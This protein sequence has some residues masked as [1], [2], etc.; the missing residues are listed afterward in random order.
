MEGWF[1]NRGVD[2]PL[3]TIPL[4]I[5]VMV[6]LLTFFYAWYG[7]SC[8]GVGGGGGAILGNGYGVQGQNYVVLLQGSEVPAGFHYR[9]LI[10]AMFLVN[11][12]EHGLMVS[13]SEFQSSN[14]RLFPRKEEY[15]IAFQFWYCEPFIVGGG[16]MEQK[17]INQS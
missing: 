7:F 10:L 15:E 8:M 2:T 14:P 6:V 16:G 4:M 11:H 17:S 9:N 13:K 5:G 3:Q 12:I 1:W